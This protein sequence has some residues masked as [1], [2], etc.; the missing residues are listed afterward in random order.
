MKKMVLRLQEKKKKRLGLSCF[1]TNW[2]TL[3]EL[4]VLAYSYKMIFMF[5]YSVYFKESVYDVITHF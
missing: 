5:I 4:D 3:C 2:G 1:H